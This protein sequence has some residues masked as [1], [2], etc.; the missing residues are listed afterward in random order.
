[1]CYLG[2]RD[3]GMGV[4]LFRM[5]RNGKYGKREI[6]DVSNWITQKTGAP[7]VGT[8]LGIHQELIQKYIQAQ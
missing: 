1:M 7:N 8:K 3:L 2:V 5:M 6:E 4:Y